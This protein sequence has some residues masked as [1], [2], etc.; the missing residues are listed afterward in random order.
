MAND[1]NAHTRVNI[2]LSVSLDNGVSYPHKHVVAAG[3]GGYVD[4]AMLSDT[5]AGVL[6]E[7]DMCSVV[8]QASHGR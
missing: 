8:F 6:L 1:A 5:W 4:V 2:S 3:K 7:D